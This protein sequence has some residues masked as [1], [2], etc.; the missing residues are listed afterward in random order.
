MPITN[1]HKLNNALQLLSALELTLCAGFDLGF[2]ADNRHYINN[3]LMFKILVYK[4]NGQYTKAR[5]RYEEMEAASVV[6]VRLESATC[7]LRHS[8]TWSR[9]SPELPKTTRATCAVK[10]IRC[11]HG[12]GGARKL[13][14]AGRVEAPAIDG[15]QLKAFWSKK[16]PPPPPVRAFGKE[17][18]M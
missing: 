13:Q 14:S 3:H 17:T 4:T 16:F 18:P 12:Q 15:R 11:L 5:K 2:W 1:K 8:S 6:E 10:L 7:W 9:G